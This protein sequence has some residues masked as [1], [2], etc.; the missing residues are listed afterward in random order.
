LSPRSNLESHSSTKTRYYRQVARNVRT[1]LSCESFVQEDWETG[2]TRTVRWR[3][4][5]TRRVNRQVATFRARVMK[6]RK[7]ICD[8]TS[9]ISSREVCQLGSVSSFLFHVSGHQQSGCILSS[10]QHHSERKSITPSLSWPQSDS[11]LWSPTY[12][13]WVVCSSKQS[14]ETIVSMFNRFWIL[15]R[16]WKW[17]IAW[18]SAQRNKCDQDELRDR[19]ISLESYPN[20][21][22]TMGM[23]AT[24]KHTC[25]ENASYER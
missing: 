4:D 25:T 2:I 15:Y 20:I 11:S 12:V 1:R 22:I 5:R 8:E 6:F 24:T 3:G 7:E 14:S 18:Y 10:H 21:H 17:I 9:L 16:S 23:S 19:D 13:M